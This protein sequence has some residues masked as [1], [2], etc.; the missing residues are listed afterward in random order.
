MTRIVNCIG[1]S[2]G[3]DSTALWG[4]AFNESGYDTATIH[5]SFAD[6]E[7]EYQE[8]IASAV[9]EQTATTSEMSRIIA[10]VAN[11]SSEIAANITAVAQATQSTTAG[12]SDT[13]RANSQ[14]GIF[15][16]AFQKSASR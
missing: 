4:W 11:G 9:E 8:T 13:K 3:K 5:G 16:K 6:T 15:G 1:L 12:A 10:E 14:P 2:G 7:N